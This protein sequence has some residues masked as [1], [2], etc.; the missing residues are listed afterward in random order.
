MPT[1]AG[2]CL[3]SPQFE[4]LVPVGR[5]LRGEGGL[6]SLRGSECNGDA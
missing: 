5:G 3:A 4:R 6:T 1:F 2:H